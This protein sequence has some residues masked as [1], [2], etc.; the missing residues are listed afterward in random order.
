MFAPASPLSPHVVV[1]LGG[2]A[3]RARYVWACTTICN[4]ITTLMFQKKTMLCSPLQA[5]PARAWCGH[6]P[7]G[8]RGRNCPD[9]RL[10]DGIRARC[11][12]PCPSG[13]IPHMRGQVRHVGV[14]VRCGLRKH[15][16]TQC[17][18]WRVW[19]CP[20]QQPRFQWQDRAALG[21]F[22]PSYAHTRPLPLPFCGP[23][24]S[25]PSGSPCVDAFLLP[26]PPP[27]HAQ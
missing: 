13:G 2:G 18:A 21:K 25:C 1:W 24:S 9:V 14:Y 12:L 17:T 6:K 10:P 4:T 3:S 22:P 16:I 15:G 11:A 19:C 23:D 20:H 27:P 7:R 26:P 8:P 5:I